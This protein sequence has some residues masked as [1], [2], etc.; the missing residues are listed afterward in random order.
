[1][2][3]A[4]LD[5]LA[6]G[7]KVCALPSPL[8]SSLSPHGRVI[9][10]PL[11]CPWFHLNPEFTLP[12]SKLL[13]HRSATEFQNSQILGTPRSGPAFFTR[14]GWGW[15]S[16][17]AFPFAGWSQENHCTS[18]QRFTD[19]DKTKQKASTETCF[20]VGLTAREQGSTSVQATFLAIQ[21]V[22]RPHSDS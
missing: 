20:S 18:A 1:M 6:L 12:A 15:G 5:S 8:H 10:L 13:N 7:E 22:F 17:H 11:L 16:H 19:C 9:H 21:G 14:W 3:R 2:T 4:L